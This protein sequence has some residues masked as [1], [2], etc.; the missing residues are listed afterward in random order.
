MQHFQTEVSLIKRSPLNVVCGV[1]LPGDPL[2]ELTCPAVT[3]GV[4]D[5]NSGLHQ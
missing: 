4:C 5:C 3:P 2:A 1:D